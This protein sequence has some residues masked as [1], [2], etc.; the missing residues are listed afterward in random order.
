MARVGLIH[1]STGR[2]R[3]PGAF[4]GSHVNGPAVQWTRWRRLASGR[5]PI[6]FEFE[7]QATP[8][9]A[10]SGRGDAAL[11]RSPGRR[12]RQFVRASKVARTCRARNCS[13]WGPGPRRSRE[14]ETPRRRRRQG[15]ARS[16]TCEEETAR[17]PHWLGLAKASKCATLIFHTYG[18]G[19]PHAERP[20]PTSFRVWVYKLRPGGEALGKIGTYEHRLRVAPGRHKLSGVTTRGETVRM[21]ARQ[22]REVTLSIDEKSGSQNPGSASKSRAAITLRERSPTSSES[23][24]LLAP[25]AGR[26]AAGS[27]ALKRRRLARASVGS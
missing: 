17:Q 13:S 2:D 12:R 1:L 11:R 14:Q 23:V 21:S 15:A 7:I 8:L 24:P 6:S 25:T 19:G 3:G 26:A 4:F 10:T 9:P 16:S 20:K 18:G 27:P 22:T 5:K